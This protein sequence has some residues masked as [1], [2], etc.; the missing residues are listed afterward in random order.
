M[1]I[2]VLGLVVGVLVA[3]LRRRAIARRAARVADWSDSDG[4]PSRLRDPETGELL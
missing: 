3:V 2:L 1:L 4:L